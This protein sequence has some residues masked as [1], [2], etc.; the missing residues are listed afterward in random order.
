MKKYSSAKDMAVPDDFKEVSMGAGFGEN[1]GKVYCGTEKGK[2]VLGFKVLETHVN[3]TGYCHGGVLSTFA[4]MQLL[5]LNES[6]DIEPMHTPTKN[7]SIDYISPVP[8]FSWLV[9][10]AELVRQTASSIY[11]HCIIRVNKK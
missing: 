3:H 10:E 1:F 7:L 6:L 9:M 2:R 8:L 11:T 4:D 5:G